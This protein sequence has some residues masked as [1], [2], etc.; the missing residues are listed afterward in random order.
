MKS[1][2]VNKGKKSCKKGVEPQVDIY[3]EPISHFVGGFCWRKQY[4]QWG[5]DRRQFGGVCW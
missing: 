3:D 1:S 4:R 5:D 2:S